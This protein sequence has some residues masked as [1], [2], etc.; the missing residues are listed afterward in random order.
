MLDRSAV[1]ERAES[2]FFKGILGELQQVR[3]HWKTKMSVNTGAPAG[4]DNWW[5]QQK[6]IYS[7]KQQQTNKNKK[8]GLVWVES[9]TWFQR[10]WCCSSKKMS[11]WDKKNNFW[12]AQVLCFHFD[13]TPIFQPRISADTDIDPISASY[14]WD[15]LWLLI[16]SFR[17]VPLSDIT[18]TENDSQQK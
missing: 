15:I 2:W 10:R 9:V 16:F 4:N 11:R 12:V 8:C 6:R 18:K 1:A 3:K 17:K 7:R 5:C 13:A 14:R